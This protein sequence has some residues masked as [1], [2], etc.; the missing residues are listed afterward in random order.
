MLLLYA[1]CARLLLRGVKRHGALRESAFQLAYISLMLAL[2]TLYFAANTWIT[3][4][5][6]IDDRDFP[7]GPFVYRES[8]FLD[9]V[10][11]LGAVVY[12]IADWFA[13]GLLVSGDWF[14][15]GRLVYA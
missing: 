13:A 1:M 7:G 2:A 9:P 15:A 14:A 10:G 3:Q 6:W 8:T 12:V 4:V 11:E 5:S